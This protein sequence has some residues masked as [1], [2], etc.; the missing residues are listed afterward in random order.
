MTRTLPIALI[1]VLIAV[2]LLAQDAA[3]ARFF[4]ERIEVR[5]A[6]RVSTDV[7][8][9]ESRLNEGQEY[10]E[11][12]LS[13]AAA[14]LS[15]LPFLLSADFSLEKGSERGRHVLVITINETKPF[16]YRLDIRPIFDNSFIGVRETDSISASDSEAFLGF[17]W[18]VGRRG[19]IH[20]GLQYEDDRRTYTEDYG[21]WAIG[22]TQ[23]DLF[24][25][26]A[27]ATVNLKRTHG[28]SGITPQVV[29]GVP[30]S[31][32]Q[33]VTVG[34]NDVQIEGEWFEV[35]GQR[36]RD[37]ESQRVGSLTW[38]Y[39]TTNHPFL[40]T[41]GT[42][43]SVTP[44]V[45]WRDDAYFQYIYDDNGQLTSVH[46]V[47]LHRRSYGLDASAARYWEVTDRTS[48]SAG[49]DAGVAQIDDAAAPVDN[50]YDA[51]Y[52][53]GRAGYSYSLWDRS[54]R[55]NGDSRLEVNLLA[56]KREDDPRSD[57]YYLYDF[58]REVVQL[59][60]SW[61]RRSSWGTVR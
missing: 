11:T 52:V 1:A 5:N 59:S 20:I 34:Y 39:N 13:D 45:A 23:Y 21:A 27:F 10:S 55:R 32:N 22:Y 7:V 30:L 3:P 6:K 57:H 56:A 53:I 17:R 50:S 18:F 41:D 29:I 40:P 12:D 2:P 15:R 9:A 44:I 43:L 24:G 46:A 26:N 58:D 16:F 42:L 33:T 48:L 36:L 60:A 47:I 19:A 54:R 38:S 35:M 37:D 4:I 25:T 28:G 49:I 31:A 14:R 61:V 8:V 51:T